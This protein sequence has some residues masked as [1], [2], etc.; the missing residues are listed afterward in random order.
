MFWIG[1]ITD[2]ERTN[3]SSSARTI[4]PA[5]TPMK[6]IRELAKEPWLRAMRS[7]ISSRVPFAS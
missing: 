3:P 5:A 2:H 7:L 6:R 1:R 4:A